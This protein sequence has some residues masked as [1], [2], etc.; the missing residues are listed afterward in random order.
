MRRPEQTLIEH[1]RAALPDHIR[2]SRAE[3][4]CEHFEIEESAPGVFSVEERFE[5]FGQDLQDQMRDGFLSLAKE[6]TDRFRVIDGARAPETVAE[7]VWAAV[8]PH[9]K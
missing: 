9:L 8:S 5:D 6:F 2:L 4:G 7:D 3:P 1:L